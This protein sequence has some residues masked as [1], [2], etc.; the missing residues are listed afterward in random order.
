MRFLPPLGLV[1]ALLA[2]SPGCRDRGETALLP[3]AHY[4][5]EAS[6]R[7][8]FAAYDKNGN[9]T[10]EGAELD[11]CPALKAALRSLDSNRDG[12][13]SRDELTARFGQYAR[14]GT[15]TVSVV[16]VTVRWNGPP[17]A[18]A[19]VT[20]TPEPF[21]GEGF[22]PAS[23]TTDDQG[24]AEMRVQGESRSGVPAGFYQ[25]TV[26][27]KGGSGGEM[28]PARYNTRTTLGRE[29]YEAGRGSPG[30]FNLDLTGKR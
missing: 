14:G 15:E 7:A 6:V 21:M 9:G 12:K 11:A 23:G 27:K 2:C 20:L 17:L 19:L 18:G 1:A 26:S 25:I 28:L 13:L 16:G 3:P 4:D 24:F 30:S 10:L 5:P 29:V 8:A 22:K